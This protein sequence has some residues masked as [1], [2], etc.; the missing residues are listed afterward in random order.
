MMRRLAL[1]ILIVLVAG[2]WNPAAPATAGSSPVR[3]RPVD[4]TFGTALQGSAPT[5]HGPAATAYDA[6]TDTIYV[7]NGFGPNK[8]PNPGGNT[9]SVIDGRRCDARS[10][11][12]CRGPW[13]TVTVGNE[14]SAIAVDPD[15]HTMYVGNNTDR[16]VSV[17][18][19]RHC[20]GS[21]TSLC[22]TRAT[23]P[24]A[25]G[26]VGMHLDAVQ[27]TVY[28]AGYDSDTVSLID[29]TTCN[30]MTPNRCPTTQVPGFATSDGPGDVDVNQ[31]T[32]TA[33]VATLLGF[34][35][36]DTRTCNAD[37]Q[38]GCVDLGHFTICDGC[39][40][41]FGARVDESTNTIYE[42][43]GDQRVVAVDGRSC[44]AASLAG[45]ATAPYGTVDLHGPRYAHVLGLVVDA[46]RH[47]V[48]V[49]S[50]KDDHVVVIDTTTCNGSHRDG[51]ALLVPDA[52]HTGTNP[53]GI[54]LDAGTHTLYV[55]NLNA[56]DLSVIDAAR[57][58]A[59]DRSGCRRL[60]DR[61]RLDTPTAVAVSESAHTAY[62]VTG[63]RITMVDL[64]TC[65]SARVLGCA[66]PHTSLTVGAEPIAVA[67]DEPRHTAYVASSA[68]TVS[69]LD[70]RR[71]AATTGGCTVTG[72][73]VLPPGRPGD[74]VTNTTT[75][76]VYVAV[77]EAGGTD[78]V[79]A[80]DASTCDATTTTGC[81]QSGGVL[82]I[83]PASDCGNP[84]ATSRLVLALD[85]PT[86]TVFAAQNPCDESVVVDSL[87]VFDGRHCH[88]GDL[89]G[90]HAAVATVRAGPDP[91]G[92]AVDEATRTLYS[93]LLGD[94]ERNGAVSVIDVRACNGT[95][96]S[97]CNQVARLAPSGFG[98]AGVAVDID[99]HDVYVTNEEDASVSVIDGTTC[100][101][102]HTTRCARTP[103]YLPTDDY[104]GVWIALAPSVST[105]YVTSPSMGTLSVL[106]MRR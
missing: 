103:T 54:A 18:D 9:V 17:V 67:V 84:Q 32:H 63:D 11:A 12:G 92:L 33:Y 23:V 36:F 13:P 15:H 79:V 58:S 65:N 3:E 28:V 8:I 56:D 86:D 55:A 91:F 48:Y 1:L 51:C 93:A 62:V 105:A 60:P 34:D 6:G 69:V 53:Q 89:S 85:R 73:L 64:R 66:G 101:S 59:P 37:T 38:E 95:V 35:A 106:P 24:V 94:G 19:L 88:G 7:A 97:G 100:R 25:A 22:R 57:C 90:C 81:R 40:G 61:V 76:T 96:T 50:H 75:G 42:G 10:V 4:A 71:C 104:P 43:D 83:G 29:T 5:G 80:F 30:G 98:S 46:A 87:R 52:V 68:G 44:N 14:P 39:Y 99:H 41:P 27:H 74:I 49:L 21:D 72:A 47:S 2:T 77:S 70:T 26:T 102:G 31:Q 16:T 78:V 20:R 45:C 82:P